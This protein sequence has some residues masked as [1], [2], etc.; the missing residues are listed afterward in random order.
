[1]T[2][3]AVFEAYKP[4]A[5]HK[6]TTLRTIHFMKNET[7]C[8]GGNITWLQANFNKC[9]TSDNFSSKN[10]NK[11]IWMNADAVELIEDGLEISLYLR[12]HENLI[13]FPNTHT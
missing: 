10:G 1:V 13:F 4:V 2:S 11:Y 9:E 12:S 5:K 8:V 3:K 7:L 6:L